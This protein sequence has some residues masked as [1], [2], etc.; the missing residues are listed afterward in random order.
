MIIILLIA[1]IYAYDL[2]SSD[3][4]KGDICI[5]S[6][7]GI[8]YNNSINLSRYDQI[9]I[10]DEKDKCYNG[11]GEYLLKLDYSGNLYLYQLST[12][13]FCVKY[14]ENYTCSVPININGTDGQIL[15][16]ED[17]NKELILV[18]LTSA[19][20]FYWN[21]RCNSYE[22]LIPN[23]RTQMKIFDIIASN[24]SAKITYIKTNRSLDVSPICNKIVLTDVNISYSGTGLVIR[25]INDKEYENEISV[26]NVS[27]LINS[28]KLKPE[29]IIQA[30]RDTRL[31]IAALAALALSDRDIDEIKPLLMASS[32]NC[33]NGCVNF[34]INR[35]K[36]MY[37]K[38]FF[39]YPNS[40]NT[41]YL[42]SLFPSNYYIYSE[43][44]IDVTL[45]NRVRNFFY[46]SLGIGN[47]TVN[48]VT[49][50][51]TIFYL[52]L[53][54]QVNFTA[55]SSN[56]SLYKG[57]VENVVIEFKNRG[58]NNTISIEGLSLEA[59]NESG[60]IADLHLE[61]IGKK[62]ADGKSLIVPIKFYIP[63]DIPDSYLKI[64]IF[65]KYEIEG[66]KIIDAGPG[67]PRNMIDIIG[68]N[69]TD[70]TSL[71]IYEFNFPYAGTLYYG[72]YYL[73][74]SAA[75]KANCILYDSQGNQIND[76]LNKEKIYFVCR[77]SLNQPIYLFEELEI[78]SKD[79]RNPPLPGLEI[80]LLNDLIKNN[81][82]ALRFKIINRM[83]ESI[84]ADYLEII[85]DPGNFRVGLNYNF[86]IKP[87]EYMYEKEIFV[88]DNDFNN[89]KI[90]ISYSLKNEFSIF[91][92]V[93]SN[94]KPI[95][96]I[97]YGMNGSYILWIDNTSKYLVSFRRP[98][99]LC[100]EDNR[101]QGSIVISINNY[102]YQH[103]GSYI[104][105]YCYYSCLYMYDSSYSP[106]Q[107]QDLKPEKNIISYYLIPDQSRIY[108]SYLSEPLFDT[109]IRSI[110]SVTSYSNSKNVLQSGLLL[111]TNSNIIKLNQS[112]ELSEGY[113]SKIKFKIK[114]NF[115]Y[116]IKLKYIEVK[117]GNDT[118]ISK[119][120]GKYIL[121][122]EQFEDS[123]SV[124]GNIK[125][126]DKYT[127]DYIFEYEFEPGLL[128]YKIPEILKYYENIFGLEVP[129]YEE[130]PVF[131]S[132]FYKYDYNDS[133]W[134][135]KSFTGNYLKYAFRSYIEIPSYAKS[136]GIRSSGVSKLYLSS[137][138]MRQ[139]MLLKDHFD[140]VIEYFPRNLFPGR[141]IVLSG[142]IKDDPQLFIKVTFNITETINVSNRP[143]TNT[144]PV[145][146]KYYNQRNYYIVKS[147]NNNPI[148]I[149]IYNKILDKLT[150]QVVYT[151]REY[152]QPGD[153]QV[154]IYPLPDLPKVYDSGNL[155]SPISITINTHFGRKIGYIANQ[156]SNI[157]LS[158]SPSKVSFY[159]YRASRDFEGKL[160]DL[161]INL[162]KLTHSNNITVIFEPIYENDEYSLGNMYV[163]CNC[164]RATLSALKGEIYVSQATCDEIKCS[165]SRNNIDLES[166]I[167]D[168][169]LSIRNYWKSNS[170]LS[171]TNQEY[172]NMEKIEKGNNK[173]GLNFY[174]PINLY[175]LYFPRASYIEVNGIPNVNNTEEYII[176]G[177]ENNFMYMSNSSNPNA[178]IYMNFLVPVLS[179]AFEV[180]NLS[181]NPDRYVYSGSTRNHNI[182]IRVYNFGSIEEKVLINGTLYRIPSL[183]A[184]TYNISLNLSP[185]VYNDIIEIRSEDGTFRYQF[186]IYLNITEPP[187]INYNISANQS[188]FFLNHNQ[189][190]SGVLFIYSNS[191]IPIN[192]NLYSDN[193]ALT[194]SNSVTINPNSTIS[195]PFNIRAMYLEDSANIT[196]Y[197]IYE[198][199]TKSENIQ[200]ILNKTLDIVDFSI[201]LDKNIS[202]INY[203]D[204]D[205]I[206]LTI[207]S[208]S[209][210]PRI[211][212]IYTDHPAVFPD[213]SLVLI[214]PNSS[215]II[216]LNLNGL[217][218]ENNTI[219]KVYVSTRNITK[220]LDILLLLDTILTNQTVNV[221]NNLL[222]A[223]TIIVDRNIVCVGEN[224]TIEV[225]E[226]G[227]YV[228][229]A[230]IYLNS[231]R[232]IHR[233]EKS[234]ITIS[235]EGNYRIYAK[236]Q[237][238]TSNFVNVYARNCDMINIDKYIYID[239][240][241]EKQNLSFLINTYFPETSPIEFRNYTFIVP[242][243]VPSQSTHIIRILNNKGEP[244]RGRFVVEV[245]GKSFYY[246]TDSLGYSLVYYPE[247]GNYRY[248]LIDQYGGLYYG[249]ITYAYPMSYYTTVSV[250]KI[251]PILPVAL[252]V[253]VIL[254]LI[255]RVKVLYYKKELLSIKVEN[256]FGYGIKGIS[257][258]IN[259]KEYKTD[260]Y[261]RINI[262]NPPESI[263]IKVPFRINI[264]D[265]KKNVD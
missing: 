12:T 215:A 124:F 44:Y 243:K 8:K 42:E 250:E 69:Y 6:N 106:Y 181:I 205:T 146:I 147:K 210:N 143:I 89:Y 48:V 26:S 190:A 105:C 51:S 263:E 15:I 233:A 132:E 54:N 10:V 85:Y 46:G 32:T 217:Y 176:L 208:N 65:K 72:N 232:Y 221:T 212:S 157:T 52:V 101:D 164:S 57:Y 255:V 165:S 171:N 180:R 70:L 113:L 27:G 264:G 17:Y 11:S 262:N 154:Y 118:I 166:Y 55:I 9:Y 223:L 161:S 81:L 38:K 220:N 30:D 62:I 135:K 237:N 79:I 253:F 115:S 179:D 104:P 244:Y 60:K 222:N 18:N 249:P 116:P 14:K 158:T 74:L 59:W 73:D 131:L 246:I 21:N 33:S 188:Y 211:Y 206:Y 191:S 153:E 168:E 28:T 182:N 88:G 254:L 170:R 77:S 225:Y 103:Y 117:A 163:F 16:I 175:S 92:S 129:R 50:N 34:S 58:L 122:D 78:V 260:M 202:F 71:S 80:I 144:L 258:K 102:S 195:V 160:N 252:G 150:K 119:Y 261:G 218:F 219:A 231:D 140:D 39:S 149:V 240:V 167:I 25:D 133:N 45:A 172:W 247:E 2:P 64:R 94:K 90:G 198:N 213:Q 227:G 75:S 125:T 173:Y 121:P 93:Y 35:A 186:V 204:T 22:N 178:E 201:Y 13:P 265:R 156:Y 130:D 187:Y 76:T 86:N 127:L 99:N 256:L 200:V 63:K 155:S 184:L 43:Q 37:V 110:L 47:F 259:N 126:L 248:Y 251:V 66:Y 19:G 56:R 226:D 109:F 67:L 3:R 145:L 36:N 189:T 239:K 236:Y 242:T 31:A 49:A 108:N 203:T 41:I 228:N 224:I 196:L 137:E 183:E 207:L 142:I 139:G 87:G 199:I 197:A 214:N 24:S 123:I 4:I 229:G 148:P 177:S 40:N 91:G 29:L 120:Y 68:K 84:E 114:S 128:I 96:K 238:K 235:E 20:L 174:I 83:L 230:I 138:N 7:V 5:I 151:A 194:I 97:R 169:D 1:L 234:I 209:T 111:N 257:I 82:N 193:P 216:R 112:V 53:P 162:S 152:I 141:K 23:S 107:M 61:Y 241:Q 185:G 95:Q 245:N 98:S 136:I 192:L 159:V 134:V 100:G